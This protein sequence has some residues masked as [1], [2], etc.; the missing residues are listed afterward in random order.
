MEPLTSVGDLEQYLLKMVA[1]QWYNF[2]RNSFHYVKQLKEMGMSRTFVYQSDF[3]ENGLLFWIGTNGK[4]VLF[5]F[6]CVC[7][8]VY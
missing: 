5:V 6:Y 4:Y 3:D 7:A 1:K 8:F 2:D